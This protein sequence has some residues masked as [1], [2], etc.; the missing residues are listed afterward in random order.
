MG[1][2]RVLLAV[3]VVLWHVKQPWAPVAGFVAVLSF[4]IISGFYMSMVIDTT[5]S[6][7]GPDWKRKFYTSRVL[8]LYPVYIV[9]FLV[10]VTFHNLIGV[11]TI[12]TAGLPLSNDWFTFMLLSNLSIVGMDAVNFI[13]ASAHWTN[14]P[15]LREIAVSWT[16]GIE[17]QYYLAA[18]FI[19]KKSIRFGMIV[20]LIALSIRFLL[21]GQSYYLW[22][23]YFAPADWCFFLLGH[24]AYRLTRDIDETIKQ[25]IGRIAAVALPCVAVI[26]Q[27][28]NPVGSDR[29][30]LWFYYIVLAASI[31][32]I[33]A[34]TKNI[35]WDNWLGNFSYP[36]YICQFP[37]IPMILFA[38]PRNYHWNRVEDV[39]L[40]QVFSVIAAGAMLYFI[41]E[42]PVDAL[43]ATLKR[44]N[45][46]AVLKPAPVSVPASHDVDR[47]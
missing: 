26:A 42:R 41:V 44:R 15:D 45:L 1:L 21:I 29:P 25:R 27:V 6:K 35:R 37:M 39:A 31:P 12:F 47:R 34:L 4:F 43:R 3:S 16:L 14:L 13:L 8:R 23:Y 30:V 24:S 11:T 46:S 9:V 18:P 28:W 2:I 5:Y 20:L 17:L 40:L 36:I 10:S 33:F 22:Q 32:F 7:M 19:V 38:V